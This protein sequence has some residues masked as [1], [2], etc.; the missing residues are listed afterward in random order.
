MLLLFLSLPNDRLLSAPVSQLGPDVN[1][2]QAVGVEVLCTF[3]MVFAIFSVEEQRRRESTEPS[4]LGI[5]LAH[6]AAVFIGVS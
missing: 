6:T 2:A 5:G 4:H 3:S 1:A